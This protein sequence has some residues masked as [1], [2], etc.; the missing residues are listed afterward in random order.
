MRK[1]REKIQDRVE[2]LILV[3]IV[4]IAILKDRTRDF[5]GHIRDRMTMT[6]EDQYMY[7]W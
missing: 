5:E 4:A 2:T 7:E 1:I 3:V 6:I